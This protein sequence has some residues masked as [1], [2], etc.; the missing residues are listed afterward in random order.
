M[1]TVKELIAQ[2]QARG[3][4]VAVEDEEGHW[5]C[6]QGSGWRQCG[7]WWWESMEY[8]INQTVLKVVEYE[9]ERMLVGILVEE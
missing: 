4:D 6:E 5:D 1:L 3:Y 2:A 9:E 8:F 7:N